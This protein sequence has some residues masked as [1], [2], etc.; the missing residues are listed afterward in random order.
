[1]TAP[2]LGKDKEYKLYTEI[3]EREDGFCYLRAEKEYIYDNVWAARNAYEEFFEPQ[4]SCD[5]VEE[6]CKEELYDKW[7]NMIG[8][9]TRM[10]VKKVY[11]YRFHSLADA[12]KKENVLKKQLSEIIQ[13]NNLITQILPYDDLLDEKDCKFR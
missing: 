9:E 8:D 2:I 10:L 7:I 3:D 6:T 4:E 12:Q 1:M 13:S 11:I 5:F